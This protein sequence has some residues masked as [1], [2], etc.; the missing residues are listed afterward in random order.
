MI[1]NRQRGWTVWGLAFVLLIISFFSLLGLKLF[2]AYLTNMKLSRA[3]NK[4]ASESDVGSATKRDIISRLEKTLYIDYA[5]EDI[6]L[7]DALTIDKGKYGMTLILD[8][9]IT[10][11][12]AYN[13]SALIEFHNSATVR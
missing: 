7:G 8:Y 3:L 13:V 12:I 11:H 9:K 1:L 5:D 10:V 6:N 2:P 4:I